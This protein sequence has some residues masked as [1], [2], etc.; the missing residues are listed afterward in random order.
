[1]AL[2]SKNLTFML[3]GRVFQ[4][5]G[6]AGSRVVSTAIIRDLYK[7]RVMAR[8]MSFIM[9]VFV[10]VPI[11]APLIG[12]GIL[13]IAHWRMIF[14]FYLILCLGLLVWFTLRLEETHTKEKR[15]P[16]SFKKI[17]KTI[18]VILADR[19]ALGYT[20]T[21]GIIFGSFLGY[22]N[23]AQQIFQSHYFFLSKVL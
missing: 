19:R 11:I 21:A 4:G 18:G 17:I 7:G 6:V 20:V 10:L 3:A 23:S 2:F 15:I 13:L 1:M 5:L 22:L 12:Q 16:F 9:T 8:V 14:V